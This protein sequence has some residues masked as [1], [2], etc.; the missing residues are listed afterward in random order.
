MPEG[1]CAVTRSAS[2]LAQYQPAGH[3]SVFTDAPG[4]QRMPGEQK[5]HEGEPVVALNVPS[6]QR[7]QVVLPA[8][9]NEPAGQAVQPAAASVPGFVTVP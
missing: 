5:A 2:E 8:V 6:G 4:K 9:E 3:C 7:A 1:H